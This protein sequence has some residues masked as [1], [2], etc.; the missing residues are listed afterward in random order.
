M[1][2]TSERDPVCGMPVAAGRGLAVERGERRLHFCSVYCRDE[3]LAHPNRYLGATA[4]SE[5]LR[6]PA[7]RRVAYFS[8]EV[9]VQGNMPTYSGGLGVLAGDMLKSCADLRIPV[10][11]VSLLYRRGYFDQTLDASG[12]Q[13]EA[14]VGWEVDRL[15]QPLPATITVPIDRRTV[16][17]R[18][19]QYTVGGVDGYGV[20]LVL[21]D[22]DMEGNTP[23]DRSLVHH[24][25]GGDRAYRLAQEMLLGIG[26]VKMLQALGYTGLR[27]YHMNEGHASLLGLALLDQGASTGP[28]APDFHAVRDRCIF[29]THT[30]VPVGHDQFDYELVERMLP[31]DVPLSLLR[32]L[33]G[34]E[35]LNMTVLGLNLSRYV[36]GVAR[37]HGEVSREMFP[38]Y[39]IHHITNGVHSSTWTC[40]S[41]KLLFDVWLPGWEGDPSMLRHAMGIPALAVWE[42][43]VEAKARLLSL[44]RERT[45]IALDAGALTIGF[46]R[47]ATAY[48]RTD[49]ALSDIS[50]LRQIARQAGPVQLVFAGKAHPK[51]EDG[52]KLIQHVVGLAGQLAGAVPIVYLENYDMD[53]AKL[54]VAG[55][56]LWLN[57]PRRPLEASGTSGMKAAHNGV[58]SLSTLDGWWPEG[59]VE[60]VTGWSIGT[61]HEAPLST[62]ATDQSDADHLYR[63]LEDDI[64]PMFYGSRDRWT[65]VMRQCIA[66]NA[67]YFNTHRMVQ[68]YASGAYLR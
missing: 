4:E 47:R 40:D 58:P 8:M 23:W 31:Q 51:D 28:Q 17:I 55:T 39:P 30:P 14:P 54:L 5:A 3:F 27:K 63:K 52:K 33:G 11:A 1:V 45:G 10:V 18:A 19:W 64:V 59:H 61:P 57:T 21:L 32:M 65:D 46:A 49:L 60:G 67:S 66:L 15:L 7:A 25:Y 68:Q 36:N 41:F 20:P 37:R 62:D 29:T 34:P 22:T 2:K 38:D 12:R 44:V 24:L 43:H 42:S 9:A 48:K 6:D 26:G 56:D 53:M 35:R 16:H 13:H 50:R